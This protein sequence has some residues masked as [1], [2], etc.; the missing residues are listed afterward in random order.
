M[1]IVEDQTQDCRK[2]DA[3]FCMSCKRFKKS[4]LRH[5][6]FVIIGADYIKLLPIHQL[7]KEVVDEVLCML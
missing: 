7:F 2:C 1:E 5:F 4:H 3:R 6:G